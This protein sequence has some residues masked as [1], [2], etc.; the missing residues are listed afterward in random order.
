MRYLIVTI[1]K[2][3]ITSGFFLGGSKVLEQNPFLKIGG[4]S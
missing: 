2:F 3:S 4:A 1:R